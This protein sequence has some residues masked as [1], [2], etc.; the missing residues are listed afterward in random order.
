MTTETIEDIKQEIS[1]QPPKF[2]KVLLHND[3]T[4]T[5]DFVIDVLTRIFHKGLQEAIEVTIAIHETGQGI[6]GSPYTKEIA[7]EKVQEVVS[8]ARA[9]G[10]PLVATFEELEN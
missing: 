4:T 6:A 3:N 8:S 7:N 10:F 1:I 5:M 9:N 2:Y